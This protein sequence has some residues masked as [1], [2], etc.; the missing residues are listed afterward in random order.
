MWKNW[1]QPCCFQD[2]NETLLF[3]TYLSTGLYATLGYCPNVLFVC[4]LGCDLYRQLIEGIG[5]DC[6]YREE[7]I[8]TIRD[9]RDRG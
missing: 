1:Q 5:R 9:G 4:N 3:E 6:R 8:G 2:C 7:E